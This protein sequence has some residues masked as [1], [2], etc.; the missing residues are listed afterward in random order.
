VHAELRPL[1][2]LDGGALRF[3]ATDGHRGASA[4][5]LLRG[6]AGRGA[7]GGDQWDRSGLDLDPDNC[8]R[9][10]KE[11]AKVATR[12][13]DIVETRLRVLGDRDDD[14]YRLLG[15]DHG[16]SWWS[17]IRILD[18]GS[19][20]DVDAVV[21]VKKPAF[22]VSFARVE[23]IKLVRGLMKIRREAWA[24]SVARAVSKL[25]VA[26]MTRNAIRREVKAAVAEARATGER[27][28]VTATR[29]MFAPRL[30]AANSAVR[31]YESDL[32][33]YRAHRNSPHVVVNVE[34]GLLQLATRDGPLA[35]DPRGTKAEIPAN[36]FVEISGSFAIDARYLLDSLRRFRSREVQIT[37]GLTTERLTH[38]SP[39]VLAAIDDVGA[40]IRPALDYEVIMPRHL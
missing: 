37:R 4:A 9:V 27:G 33:S 35:S 7:C 25:K 23:M 3:V 16:T 5:V 10:A 38:H 17:T 29:R 15:V 1:D 14:G 32:S 20:P 19:F 12:A 36:M 11:L 40:T 8:A 6:A 21:V 2:G 18:F 24:P 13:K 34:P 39:I 26:R 31:G 30:E 22:M 28:A